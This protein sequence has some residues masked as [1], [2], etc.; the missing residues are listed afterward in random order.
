MDASSWRDLEALVDR[1][2]AER[3]AALLKRLRLFLR[4]I[5][6]LPTLRYGR[7]FTSLD[8]QRRRRSLARLQ[9]SRFNAIRVGFWGVRTLALM[10]YYGRPH[11]ARAIGYDAHPDGWEARA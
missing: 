8:P 11:A 9:E 4:L 10:G 1:S 5:D 6:L 7:R 2:L 3:P